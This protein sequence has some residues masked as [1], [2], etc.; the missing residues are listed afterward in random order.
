VAR[1]AHRANTPSFAALAAVF[2]LVELSVRTS[3]RLL[4]VLAGLLL[5]VSACGTTMPAGAAATVDGESVSRDQLEQAVSELTADAPEE[6]RA[7]T[8]EQVQRQVLTLLIQAKV[9]ENLAAAEDIEVDDAEVE[10]RI[11]ADIEQAGGEDELAEMLTFQQLTLDLYREVLVPTQLRVDVLRQRLAADLPALETRSVRHILVETEEEAQDV[12]AELEDG[13]DFAALAEERS[14]DPGSGAQGGDLG[15]NPRGAFVPEFDDAAWDAEV[16]EIVGPI[17]SQF[18]FHVLEVTDTEETSVDDMDVQQLDQ[19][20][21]QDL[22][23]QLQEAFQAAEVTVDSAFGEWD[24]GQTAVVPSGQVGEGGEPAPQEP[25]P[26]PDD[27]G[28]LEVEEGA[29]GELE[30]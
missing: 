30:E 2:D 16:G 10:E 26:A 5:L 4:A 6:D 13:A 3:S 7:E 24:A 17:E 15:S 9:I 12:V 14:T 21:G 27:L 19:L 1:L 23:A 28:D 22:G 29:D 18:G 25:A 8:T 11:E 20:V